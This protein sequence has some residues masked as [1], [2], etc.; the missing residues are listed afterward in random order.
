[1]P[2][3]A[4]PRHDA[5]RGRVRQVLAPGNYACALMARPSTGSSPALVVR[6]WHRRGVCQD[7]HTGGFTMQLVLLSNVIWTRS[8]V[9]SSVVFALVSQLAVTLRPLNSRHTIRWAG[10]HIQELHTPHHAALPWGKGYL[11]G[12]VSGAGRNTMSTIGLTMAPAEGTSEPGAGLGQGPVAQGGGG[13]AQA[14]CECG[15]TPPS[16]PALSSRANFLAGRA[17]AM[18]HSRITSQQLHRE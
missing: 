16:S 4:L 7:R 12:Q 13:Y 18:A 9:E 2:M 11:A 6:C 3:R 14:H 10:V 15:H 17:S 1:M 5:E 8:Q